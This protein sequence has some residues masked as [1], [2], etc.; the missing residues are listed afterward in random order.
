MLLSSARLKLDRAGEH[1]KSI[2]EELLA[3]VEGRPHRVSMDVDDEGWNVVY[4]EIVRPIPDRMGVLAGDAAHCI[5]SALDHI[6][7][8]VAK[9]R[10]RGSGYFPI[11]VDEDDYLRPRGD[12]PSM[13][14]EGLAGV[15]EPIK[16][17]IDST[18]PYHG[19]DRAREHIFAVVVR[20]DNA[21]KHR[22]I[23][24][25]VGVIRNPGTIEAPDVAY[26]HEVVMETD[27]LHIGEPLRSNNKTPVLRWRTQPPL[28]EMNV[29][30]NPSLGIFIGEGGA[31]DH[32][33]RARE[34]VYKL[35]ERIE[36]AEL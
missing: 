6:V 13:R 4:V 17:I 35:I 5:R 2:R 12:R 15:P 24:P 25:T 3:Y 11:A 20:I 22:L 26:G 30:F 1:I 21:D 27:W 28:R 19:G 18:Q 36:T 23:Q 14:D 29:K 31:F 9:G 32:L 8:A 33:V 10:N 16:T 34:Q 7:Y